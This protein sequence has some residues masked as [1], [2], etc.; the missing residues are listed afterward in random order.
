MEI[1]LGQQLF[2]DRHFGI[3]C[4]E[5][6]A[7]RQKDGAPAVLF[8]PIHDDRH[9]E[10]C[11]FAAA[12]ISREILLH[13]L[14]FVAAVRRIHQNDIEAVA[15]LVLTHIL[16]QAVAVDDARVVDVVE[17]HIRGAQ[18]ER[19]CLLFD[20]VNGVAVNCSVLDALHLGV[21]HLQRRGK[22]AAGTAGKVYQSGVFDTGGYESRDEKSPRNKDSRG[23]CNLG[24]PCFIDMC[25]VVSTRYSQ[26]HKTMND[27][28][29]Y[30]AT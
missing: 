20:T 1:E 22:E 16:F 10:V 23:V 6:E 24:S 5:Q 3:I 30:R 19:Q 8:Q 18:K 21:Q 4:A 12:E 14:F 15:L 7:V 29:T 28:W 9:K 27:S 17:Q 2:L 13:A 26:N 11:G 25:A